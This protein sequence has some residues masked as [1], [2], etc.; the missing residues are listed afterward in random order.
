MKWFG[1]RLDDEI[2]KL[3]ADAAAA[4]V[5]RAQLSFQMVLTTPKL[6]ANEMAVFWAASAGVMAEAEVNGPQDDSRL[7]LSRVSRDF[8]DSFCQSYID[9]IAKANLKLSPDSEEILALITPLLNQMP[10]KRLDEVGH[11]MSAVASNAARLAG[12]TIAILYRGLRE[13]D[14]DIAR[15]HA[16]S[17]VRSWPGLSAIEKTTA[18]E[19]LTRV[20]WS[21][22]S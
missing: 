5:E 12:A 22:T 4:Y 21:A 10:K 8:F 20:S 14:A 3:S 13:K 7:L 15:D 19:W 1:N 9:N 2:K 16:R 18:D 11:L 17:L 6:S